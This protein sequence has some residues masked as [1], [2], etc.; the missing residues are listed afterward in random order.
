MESDRKM[1]M[2]TTERRRKGTATAETEATTETV[3]I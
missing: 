2:D 3:G 1:D